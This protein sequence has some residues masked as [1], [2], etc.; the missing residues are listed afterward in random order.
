M[1]VEN[2]SEDR[3]RNAYRNPSQLTDADC[4]E[5]RKRMAADNKSWR[6]RKRREELAGGHDPAESKRQRQWA[7]SKKR[8]NNNGI[9]REL[10]EDEKRQLSAAWG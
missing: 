3:I 4:V 10:N 6:T 8:R 7:A 2:Y 5:I 1:S 9:R